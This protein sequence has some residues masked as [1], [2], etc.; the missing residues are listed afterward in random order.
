MTF[1]RPCIDLHEG[2]VKQIVGGSI[3]TGGAITNFISDKDAAHYAN[4]YS[5]HGL[6]GGHIISLGPNN[7]QEVMRALAAYPQ[8]LQYGGGVNL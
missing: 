3:T 6:Q 2:K 4:L 1:F 7:Q 8:V 5:E